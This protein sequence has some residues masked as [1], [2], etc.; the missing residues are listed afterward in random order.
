MISK[1]LHVLMNR[2]VTEK[3]YSAVGGFGFEYTYFTLNIGIQ[4]NLP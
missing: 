1:G 4:R 3:G 2:E